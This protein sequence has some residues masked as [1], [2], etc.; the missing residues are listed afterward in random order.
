MTGAPCLILVRHGESLWNFERRFTGWSDP[1]LT[2]RGRREAGAAGRALA[3][4]SLTPD[5]VFTSVLTRAQDTVGELLREL[6]AKPETVTSWRLNERNY[7]ALE[8]MLHEEARR[9][10]GAEAVE[11]WRRDWAAVPPPL[12]QT[13][14]RHPVHNARYADIDQSCR[15]GGESLAEC[16][17][18]Q[19]PLFSG[20]IGERVVNGERIL[21]V[22]H[23]NALRALVAHIEMISPPDVPRLLIPTGVPLVYRPGL[24]WQR[25]E[26]RFNVRGTW[27]GP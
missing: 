7:G 14:S 12:S 1:P 26:T 20:E 19:L 6:N 9:R 2:S 21:L 11:R 25:V 16:L 18:R 4:R 8:G 17:G 3:E 24:H 27:T 10:Y 13:D 15:P 23:G 22:G 5:V